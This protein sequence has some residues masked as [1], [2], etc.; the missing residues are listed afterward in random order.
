MIRAGDIHI[1]ILN[2]FPCLSQ[3]LFPIWEV[4]LGSVSTQYELEFYS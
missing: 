2:N 3:N 1:C 4:L